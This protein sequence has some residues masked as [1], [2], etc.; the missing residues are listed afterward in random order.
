M[1]CS[2]CAVLYID[3]RARAAETLNSSNVKDYEGLLGE[4]DADHNIRTLLSIFN[5]GM[6]ST[7]QIMAQ[8][9]TS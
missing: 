6:P 9:D 2:A 5:Q 4:E 8:Q 7:T 3:R 1:D